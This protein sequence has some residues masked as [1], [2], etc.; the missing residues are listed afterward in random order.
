MEQ[1]FRQTELEVR[2]SLNMNV[3]DAAGVP[4]VMSLGRGAGGL[5][6]PPHGGAGPPLAASARQGHGPARGPRRLSQGLP[7][8]RRGDPD[9]PRGGR[10][11][12]GADGALRAD[13]PAGRGDPQP[14]PAQPAQARGDGARGRADQAGRGARRRWKRCSPTTARAAPGPAQGGVPGGARSS[15]AAAR[16][17]SAGP[18]SPT[19]RRSHRSCSRSRSSAI[20]SPSSARSWA[21]SARSAVRSRTAAD[22]KYKE[23]DGERFVLP[24]QSSD[25][26]LVLAADGRVYTLAVDRLAR[27]PRPWRAAVA[28]RSTSRRASRSST[29]ASTAPTAGWC[30][31]PAR[32]SAS[33]PRRRRS[34]PRPAPAGRWSI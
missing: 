15:S 33:S 30:S 14:P 23:G 25:R 10:A 29:C 24:A 5:P 6:R 22:L 2:L 12:A 9:H 8:P 17:A 7:R 18:S 19:R 3:L 21:G 26:L 27:R 11:Q 1:L 4:R 32:A 34:W 13:R 16:S 31:P 28:R 20:R